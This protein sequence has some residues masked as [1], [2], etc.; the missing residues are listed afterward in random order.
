MKFNK[1]KCKV[2][3]LGK[4]NPR[5]Q[6]RL[7]STQLRKSSMER[8][9][10][11]QVDKKLNMNE[12]CAAVAEQTKRM[13]GFINKDITI[14]EKEVIISAQHLSGHTWNIVFSCG[15]CY[16]EKDVDRLG[17]VQRGVPKM[18]KDFEA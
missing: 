3:H 7:G 16:T 1:D 10:G 13:T 8:D 9:L 15:P 11:V 6:H 12:G 4:H 17:K 18:M 14:R 5:V 2:L